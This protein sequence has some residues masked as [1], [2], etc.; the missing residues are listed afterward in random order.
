MFHSLTFSI[1]TNYG[2]T[3]DT[4]LELWPW[5]IRNRLRVYIIY[6]LSL[7]TGGF[8]H[9]DDIRALPSS[10][11]S[12]E[13]QISIVEIFSKGNLLKLNVQ[14]CEIVHFSLATL[15][16]HQ[17]SVNS[18]ISTKTAAQCL[19]YWWSRDLLS[20]RSVEEN[21]KEGQRMFFFSSTVLSG[22]IPGRHQPSLYEIC[23]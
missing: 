22:L 19:G 6:G 5:L 17:E 3:S 23:D 2:S 1:P 13:K 21:I 12:L 4:P 15:S 7:Y 20:N 16:P 18:H 9:V 14:K 10:T 11:E 8:I